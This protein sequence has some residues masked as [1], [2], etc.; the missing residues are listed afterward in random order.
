M[1]LC[2]S[3]ESNSVT[4]D[5]VADAPFTARGLTLVPG[6]KP[7]AAECALQIAEHDSFRTV[8]EFL[9]DRTNMSVSVGPMPLGNVTRF[10]HRG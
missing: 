10:V 7:W 8:K 6:E 2:G 1:H 9:F 5:L 4:I 3:G